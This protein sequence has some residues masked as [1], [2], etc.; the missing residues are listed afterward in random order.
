MMGR[1]VAKM[2]IAGNIRMRLGATVKG[3]FSVWDSR[4][5]IR[6]AGTKTL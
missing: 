5:N 3:A 2:P 1:P 4:K 6:K